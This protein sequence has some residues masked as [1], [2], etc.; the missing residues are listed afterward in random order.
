MVHCLTIPHFIYAFYC[1]WTFGLFTVCGFYECCSWE[2]SHTCLSVHILSYSFLLD[3]QKWNC[4]VVDDTYMISFSRHY[5]FS[6]VVLPVHTPTSTKGCSCATSSPALGITHC[7]LISALTTLLNCPCQDKSD[8]FSSSCSLSILQH[9]RACLS[10]LEMFY[11]FGFCDTSL[12]CFPPTTWSL[13]SLLLSSL[14]S[15]HPLTVNV[16][17]GLSLVS[18]F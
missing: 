16:P 6:K 1:W 15:L 10:I 12:S 9:W 11:S 5:Q 17:Q 18:F 3:S 14:S 8:R 2:H 4:W 7:I 13:L